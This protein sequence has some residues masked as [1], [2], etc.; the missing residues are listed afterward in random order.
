[1][2]VRAGLKRRLT[3]LARNLRVRNIASVRFF[4]KKPRD[5][6]EKVV[7]H[8]FSGVRRISELSPTYSVSRGR[9]S[10]PPKSM[11]LQSLKNKKVFKTVVLE[12]CVST[13]AKMDDQQ[14]SLDDYS[15]KVRSL[16]TSKKSIPPRCRNRFALTSQLDNRINQP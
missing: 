11:P 16:R 5:I 10:P 12:R 9:R 14:R 3:D 7:R 1:M 15:P 6:T 8:S 2:S 13:I 4:E